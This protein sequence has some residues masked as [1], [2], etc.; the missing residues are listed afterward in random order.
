VISW[1]KKTM[2]HRK[3]GGP[4]EFRNPA[5]KIKGRR[6][7]GGVWVGEKKK[8]VGGGKTGKTGRTLKK[9]KTFRFKLGGKISVT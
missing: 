1:K 7:R 6:R 3:K 9:G 5:S 2:P 8:R 4:S